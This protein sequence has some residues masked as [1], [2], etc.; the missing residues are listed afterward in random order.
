[1]SYNRMLLNMSPPGDLVTAVARGD[2]LSL[3][4]HCFPKGELA[5]RSL[6]MEMLE[7]EHKAHS[8]ILQH[9]HKPTI[10]NQ[11][12]ALGSELDLARVAFIAVI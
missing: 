3:H 9:R 11:V 7:A 12:T 4:G 10:T 5:L 2:C 6:V 1:M 8:K